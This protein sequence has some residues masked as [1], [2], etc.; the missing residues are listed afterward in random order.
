MEALALPFELLENV[1]RHPTVENAKR[2]SD[3]LNSRRTLDLCSSG[4]ENTILV[5]ILKL[6]ASVNVR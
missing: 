1:W 3:A 5:T 4:R 6:I 2:L